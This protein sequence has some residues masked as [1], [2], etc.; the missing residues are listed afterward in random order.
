MHEPSSR[1]L[2]APVIAGLMP[3]P[4]RGNCRRRCRPFRP[5]IVPSK[6]RAD[7]NVT[8]SVDVRNTGGRAGDEV[9]QLY[10]RDLVGS[11]TTCEQ[12]LRGFERIHLAPG[13]RRT[14]GFAPANLALP[15]REIK[16][17]I[18]PGKFR[19]MV[20]GGSQAIRQQAEFEIEP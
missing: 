12:N 3:G 20:G 19:V 10:T 15:D 2:V 7:G 18:E 4:G 17:V 5:C 8:A 11:V 9:V 14:V 13:E 6:Q 16:R 1:A